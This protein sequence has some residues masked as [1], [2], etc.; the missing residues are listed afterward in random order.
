MRWGFAVLL[1]WGLILRPAV[2][3]AESPS[4]IGNGAMPGLHR[5]RAAEPF[6]LGPTALVGLGYGFTESVLAESDQHHSTMSSIALSYAPLAWL[7]AG[8]GWGSRFD[9]HRRR[10]DTTFTAVPSL[11]VSVM[12]P[13]S[14]K[15]WRAGLE[16]SVWFPTL[17]SAS[18][19]VLA[20]VSNEPAANYRFHINAGARLDRS[21]TAIEDD[22]NTLMNSDLLTLGSSDS[23]ALL[24]AAGWDWRVTPKLDVYG[25]WSYDL[26]VGA[27]APSMD[28]SPMR[29]AVGARFPLSGDYGL[30]LI[31]ETTINRPQVVD[32]R[33]PLVP[34]EPMVSFSV[35]LQ[36]RPYLAKVQTLTPVPTTGRI[37]GSLTTRDR[38]PVPNAKVTAGGQEV[39]TSASGR[40][41]IDGL[42]IG[43]IAIEID[44]KGYVIAPIRAQV[45][46]GRTHDIL[47]TAVPD[48]TLGQ[49]RVFVRDRMGQGLE[50]TLTISPGNH[51]LVANK[52]GEVVIDLDSGTY[53]ILVES[54]SHGEQ[55][56]KVVL[57][58]YGV[59]ILNV[60]LMQHRIAP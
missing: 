25:E 21:A 10:A 13:V 19:D 20:F 44:A 15:R 50:A 30:S 2:A 31:T 55:L 7:S 52:A 56:R 58:P 26:L 28:E 5:V 6:R 51:R 8:V 47:V 38:L 14:S 32:G 36:R 23:N 29:F 9:V 43:E 24:F 35:T 11:R 18:V 39:L 60:D 17:S 42:E 45:L 41:A 46:P 1:L 22:R 37:E 3:V 4:G 16:S 48:D 40:F 53:E 34:L 12:L 54:E 27:D 57:A 49:L 33:L 59:T